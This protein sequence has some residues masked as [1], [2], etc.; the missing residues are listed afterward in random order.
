MKQRIIISLAV[1]AV[2]LVAAT[3]ALASTLTA[4]AT[5]GGTAGI[6]LNLPSAPSISDTLDGSDQTVSYAPILGV[7]DARGTGAGWNLTIAA[8]TFSDSSG[9]TLAAGDVS[10]VSAACH[11]GAT[12]TAATSSGI[13]YPLSLT[14]TA[15]KVFNAALNTGL[16]KVDV[17]P[18]VQVLIPGN[19]YAA[20]YTSTLTLATTT[21]P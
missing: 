18:T 11:A 16:G 8:T 2:A 21:G 12:C 1:A 5:I 10:A 9:H 3:A 6:S 20:T 4:T 13:T 14:T 15:A 19:S 7:V 17:T